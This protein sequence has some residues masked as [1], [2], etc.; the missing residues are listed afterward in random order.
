MLADIVRPSKNK[1][2]INLSDIIVHERG[3]WNYIV[4]SQDH[5]YY[6][7]GLFATPTGYV[8]VKWTLKAVK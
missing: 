3:S 6:F 5:T 1:K 7:T 4:I 8:T 2:S